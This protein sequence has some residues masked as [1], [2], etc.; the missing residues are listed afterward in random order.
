ME[1]V[2]PTYL[3]YLLRLRRVNE[4]G[5]PVWRISLEAP[6][7]ETYLQFENLPALFAYLAAQIRVVEEEGGDT[8]EVKQPQV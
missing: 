4:A 5:Q 1:K 6:G 3:S 8:E 2:H 7:G